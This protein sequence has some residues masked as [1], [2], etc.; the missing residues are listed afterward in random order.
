MAVLRDYANSDPNRQEIRYKFEGDR[1][2]LL[3]ELVDAIKADFF[4]TDR[5]TVGID[6]SNPLM[7]YVSVVRD[8]LAKLEV[9]VTGIVGEKR[10][11]WKW[12]GI[13]RRETSLLVDDFI[14]YSH[15]KV[16]R[17]GKEVDGGMVIEPRGD[18]H[19][20]SGLT[21]LHPGGGNY[22]LDI[23]VGVFEPV[24]II[25]FGHSWD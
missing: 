12:E 19:Y 7:P 8:L 4:T 9:K 16:L 1:P 11:Q 21:K 18:R 25:Q 15:F 6:A 13:E 24:D 20:F 10:F 23:P 2:T 14:I 5:L 22:F 17:Y 3:R